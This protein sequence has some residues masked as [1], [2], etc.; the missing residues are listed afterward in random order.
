MLEPKEGLLTFRAEGNNFRGSRYYSRKIHWPGNSPACGKNA[1]GVTIGRGF[2]LGGRSEKEALSY[3]ILAGIPTEKAIK[4]SAGS[5]LTH[6]RADEFVKVNKDSIGE[7]T[8]SQQLRLFENVYRNYLYDAIRF[9]NKY[10]NS[11]S[12][13]WNKLD[14]KVKDVFV[15]MKY[16]GVLSKNMVKFFEKNNRFDVIYL[17]ENDKYLM[18]YESS[19]GRLG[20]LKDKS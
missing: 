2:D 14:K 11:G 12:E 1:S 6:C 4:I 9:Y 3:L 8:E 18:S 16:Q 15:D 19:R 5:K 13:S 7:I 20:Y 17:I 10:K